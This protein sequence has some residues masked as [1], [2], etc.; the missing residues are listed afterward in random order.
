MCSN[1]ILCS[2]FVLQRH[3]FSSFFV[4]VVVV[5]VLFLS[6]LCVKHWTMHRSE[7]ID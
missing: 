7:D 2:N 3:T 1:F 5:V 4:V 6:F